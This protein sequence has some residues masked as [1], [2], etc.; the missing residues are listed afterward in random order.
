MTESATVLIPGTRAYRAGVTRGWERAN[1]LYLD[2]GIAV[3][4]TREFILRGLPYWASEE[5]SDPEDYLSG[6][7]MGFAYRVQNRWPNG[8]RK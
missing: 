4:P 3:I 2:E 5:G 1:R 8:M 6:Y 7:A